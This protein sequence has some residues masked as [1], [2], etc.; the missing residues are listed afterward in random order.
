MNAAPAQTILVIDDEPSIL[1]MLERRL[2]TWD[3]RVMVAENGRDGIACIE[4][5]PPDAVITDL[6]MPETDGFG[7]LAHINRWS[8]DL[9]VIVLS[10]QGRLGDAIRALRLGAWDYIYKPIEEMGFLRMSIDKVLERAQLVKENR[11]YRDHLEQLVAEKMAALAASEKRYRTVADFT[12][13]WEYWIDPDGGIR[14]MSPSCERV[15]GYP[16]HAFEADPSLFLEVVH[17]D[18]RDTFKCHMDGDAREEGVFYLDFR[19]VRRDGELRW[20]AHICQPIHDAD[21]SFLGRRGNNRDITYRKKMENDLLAQQRELT[22]KTL[23]LERA[24]EALKVLLDQ[25]EIEKRSIEQAMV[26]NLKRFVFPYLESLKGMKIG[27]EAGAYT[28]IIRANIEQ[29]ISPVSKRL[30]GAYLDFTPA[31]IRVADLIRQGES[32]KSIAGILNTSPATV[33]IHRNKIRQKLGLLNQKV[34]LRTYL[35]NL[36]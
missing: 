4:T 17:P 13:D 2:T 8:P 30:S 28:E 5:D 29:L 33:A 31:E 36:A 15:T 20:I 6:F 12:Y 27:K 24:N 22:E 1:R 26:A 18:D 14:Y 9:P 32:S 10:G 25:R 7:V 11:N 21:G 35:N 16:P 3:F 19:I 23:S 34:N